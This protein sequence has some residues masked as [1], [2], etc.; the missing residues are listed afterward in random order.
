MTGDSDEVRELLK[1]TGGLL[2]NRVLLF[3]ISSISSTVGI[4]PMPLA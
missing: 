2:P 4:S 1:T 3:H